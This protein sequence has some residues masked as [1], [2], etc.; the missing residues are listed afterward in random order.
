MTASK[1][2]EAIGDLPPEGQI[3]VIQH[4]INLARTH[5]LCAE[6]LGQMADR[7]SVSNDPAEILRLKSALSCGFY[8]K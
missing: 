5:Q 4:A 7:L 3:K 6:E 2:I 8:G 1:V